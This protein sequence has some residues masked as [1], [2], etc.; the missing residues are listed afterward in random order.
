[1]F[2]KPFAAVVAILGLAGLP[3]AAA[4]RD[5]NPYTCDVC[6]FAVGA[7]GSAFRIVVG[8]R[9]IEGLAGVEDL[10]PDG[11]KML[12]ARQGDTRVYVSTVT[13]SD[14]RVVAESGRG[15]VFSPDG[16]KV[17]FTRPSPAGS[18]SG[19]PCAASEVWVVAADGSGPARIA[20][21]AA[22]PA[23]APDSR[24]LAFVGSLAPSEDSGRL[25]IGDLGGATSPIALW[26]GGDSSGGVD[27][28]WSPRGDLVAYVAAHEP[29]RPQAIGGSAGGRASDP[30]LELR[31]VRAD[32]RPVRAFA[33]SYAPSWSPDGTRIVFDHAD[34]P[35]EDVP[36]SL[37]PGDDVSLQLAP[38][39]GRARR[40]Y[41]RCG[42]P[43]WSPDGRR[44]ACA[45]L[46][47]CRG[48]EA[49]DQLFVV[50]AA[51]G[52]PRQVTCL[53]PGGEIR[54]LWWSRDG[55]QIL[56]SWEFTQYDRDARS[57]ALRA[58][59]AAP[60]PLSHARVCP[61]LLFGGALWDPFAHE[62]VA[63]E[64]RGLEP[65]QVYD[66]S[67]RYRAPRPARFSARLL[68]EHRV[69]RS[70]STTVSGSGTKGIGV[71][72]ASLPEDAALPAGAYACEFS[73]GKSRLRVAFRPSGPAQTLLV[74]LACR[75]AAT[76]EGA[77]SSYSGRSATLAAT[78]S[79]T[80][81]AI[82]AR[83]QG[84]RVE[85]DFLRGGTRLYV[86]TDVLRYPIT[87]E[88]AHTSAAH[89]RP[90][91][92]GDYR[93]RFLVGGQLIAE[94]AFTVLAQY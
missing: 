76:Y 79:V 37:A 45:G 89:G 32:G 25:T 23:W 49:T 70:Y 81:S 66:C 80:C 53:Q 22:Y 46:G 19:P 28:A 88:W 55:S 11:T 40:G 8:D 93:C 5:V 12:F 71:G 7:D 65:G 38:L 94:K 30:P 17:A 26:E 87:S 10:S 33:A 13:G 18:P 36:F 82:V 56:F 64:R 74:P 85:I 62:C 34:S 48:A 14:A 15:P 84:R 58:V 41:G 73:L 72:F 3:A 2:A 29:T 54:R 50:A 39:G 42:A 91:P 27:A 51:G 78:H 90:L 69:Q 24:R 43:T 6:L 63:D 31:V 61:S 59:T 1:L 20:D 47:S 35:Y 67:V 4:P 68:Y 86:A 52:R 92:A 75:T 83:R 77:C 9:Q 16:T 44:I 60:P 21:C 57:V